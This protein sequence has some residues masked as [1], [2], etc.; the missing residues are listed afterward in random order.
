[1]ACH[2]GVNLWFWKN[3]LTNWIISTFFYFKLGNLPQYDLW[4]VFHFLS[5]SGL[6]GWKDVHD[7]YPFTVFY[8]QSSWVSLNPDHL[9]SDNTSTSYKPAPHNYI[10]KYFLILIF[11]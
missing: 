8:K 5:E 1:M 4:R 2:I 9:D 11:V 6:S 7:G 10:N 3:G